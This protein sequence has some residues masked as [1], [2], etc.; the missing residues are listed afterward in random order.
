MSNFSPSQSPALV[1]KSLSKTFGDNRALDN[2]NLSVDPGEIYCML[3]ANGAGKTTTINLFL[4]FLEPSQGVALVSG[5]DV[6]Q[7]P[8]EARAKVTYLPEQVALYPELTGL[9]NLS[10][11]LALSP[12]HKSPKQQ[13]AD[14]LDEAGL[15]P[16]HHHR[17]VGGYSKGMRQ[18]V[19]IALAIAKSSEVLLLD[20]PTSGLDPSS[21]NEFSEILLQLAHQG[22]AIFM[23]THDLFRVKQLSQRVGIMKKGVLVEERLTAELEAT[24]LEQL[25]LQHMRN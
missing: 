11:L 14:F 25:Y 8:Q 20:E 10:Y 16:E 6:S 15:A 24:E 1:A 4:N 12:Q 7:K 19:G 18:K 23:V 22:A 17:R 3:G 13:L 5:I 21:A 9:E 2:L